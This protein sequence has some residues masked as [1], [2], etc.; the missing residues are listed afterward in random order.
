MI[1]DLLKK[2]KSF[3]KSYGINIYSYN[4]NNFINQINVN[5]KIDGI[6]AIKY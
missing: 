4:V 6:L 2:N 3:I 5:Q 1:R